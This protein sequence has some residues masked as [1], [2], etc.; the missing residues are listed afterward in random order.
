LATIAGG[1][2]L[3]DMIHRM[4]EKIKCSQLTNIN[5]T[6]CAWIRDLKYYAYSTRGSTLNGFL[7]ALDAAE[8]YRPDEVRFGSAIIV[9]LWRNENA[10]YEIIVRFRE[11]SFGTELRNVTKLVGVCGRKVACS[12]N[13]FVAGS[14]T[15]N[16]GDFQKYCAKRISPINS[17]TTPVST[18]TTTPVSTTTTTSGTSSKSFSLLSLGSYFLASLIINFSVTEIARQN[19]D[20]SR[21]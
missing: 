17:T 3:W 9:E 12:W 15:Y 20:E 2:L 8:V 4:Q 5:K 10:Q 16:P 13:D 6:E 21:S 7:A 18:T 11:K 1:N 19:N 14:E